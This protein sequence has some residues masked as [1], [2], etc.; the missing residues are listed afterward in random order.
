MQSESDD[1]Q[2]ED[3]FSFTVCDEALEEAASATFSLGNCT[4]SRVCPV[5]D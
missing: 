2:K 5:T 3:I 4:D 1:L